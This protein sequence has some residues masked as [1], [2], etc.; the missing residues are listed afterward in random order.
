MIRPS[1]LTGRNTFARSLRFTVSNY[2]RQY[3]N[4]L[5]A[6]SDESWRPK[7]NGPLDLSSVE[8]LR[9]EHLTKLRKELTNPQ[10]PAWAWTEAQSGSFSAGR[11]TWTRIVTLR[12]CQ[13]R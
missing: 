8:M 6:E 9:K 7:Y 2:L 1:S 10:P 5:A 12:R 4:L 3:A 11:I 13:T